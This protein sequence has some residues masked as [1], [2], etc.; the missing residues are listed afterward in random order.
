ML[1]LPV[2]PNKAAPALTRTLAGALKKGQ[3]LVLPTDTIYGLSCLADNPAALRRIY[4]FKGRAATKPM[5]SLVG[6]LEILKHYAVLNRAQ[7]QTLRKIW[8]GRRPTTVILKAKKGKLA[9]I[10]VSPSGG[11]AVRLPKNVFLLK[12]LKELGRP[13]VSTSINMS[14]QESL[15]DPAEIEAWFGARKQKP[16]IMVKAGRCRKRRASRLIDLRFAGPPLILRK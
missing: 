10:L 12:M 7:A 8:S 2:K 15:T 14:G 13:I 4:R 6:S 5:I 9:P 11:I 3:V 1:I 16:D